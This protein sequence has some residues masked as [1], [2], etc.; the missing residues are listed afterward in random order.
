MLELPVV[1]GFP[2]LLY[3]SVLNEHPYHLYHFVSFHCC[4][5][6]LLDYA[7][8]VK[9]ILLYKFL[10]Q[11]FIVKN[12]FSYNSYFIFHFHHINHLPVC[13]VNIFVVEVNVDV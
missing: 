10:L 13:V 5:V 6:L 3:P 12:A 7:K 9:I 8:V 11:K 1:G 2:L 4:K